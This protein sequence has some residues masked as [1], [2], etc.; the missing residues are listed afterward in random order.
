LF[1]LGSVFLIHE[2]LNFARVL[3][4]SFSLFVVSSS[5]GSKKILFFSRFTYSFKPKKSVSSSFHCSFILL[6]RREREK[7]ESTNFPTKTITEETWCLS[8]SFVL[9]F[10]RERKKKKK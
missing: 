1:L 9:N 4:F 8:N 3:F 10:E 7:K 2:Q 6:K 5:N